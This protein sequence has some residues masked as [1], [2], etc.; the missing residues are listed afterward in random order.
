MMGIL[1]PRGLFAAPPITSVQRDLGTRD[2]LAPLP[3]EARDSHLEPRQ[4]LT[5]PSCHTASNRACWGNFNIN[6]DYEVNGPNTGVTR[7][8]RTLFDF[9]A[10]SSQD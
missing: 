2:L 1:A 8:V 9:F 4:A 7:T 6:T 5:P 10:N 3:V